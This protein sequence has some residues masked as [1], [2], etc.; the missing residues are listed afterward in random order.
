MIYKLLEKAASA[1]K[2]VRRSFLFCFC[3]FIVSYGVCL[4][5]VCCRL[6]PIQKTIL[7][8]IMNMTYSCHVMPDMMGMECEKG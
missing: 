1:L 7:S 5:G 2:D 3:N 6:F 8:D 4:L